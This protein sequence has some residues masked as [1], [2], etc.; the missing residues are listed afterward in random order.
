MASGIPLVQTKLYSL[1]GQVLVFQELTEQWERRTQT[2]KGTVVTDVR[3]RSLLCGTPSS[4][5]GCSDASLAHSPD[6]HVHLL[7]ITVPGTYKW[8][9]EGGSGQVCPHGIHSLVSKTISHS[10]V[11]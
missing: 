8:S 11:S 1:L 3:V 7:F 2:L 9:Q 6:T 4:V 10:I 5:A